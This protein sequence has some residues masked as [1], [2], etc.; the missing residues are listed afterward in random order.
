MNLTEKEKKKKH[1]KTI[2]RQDGQENRGRRIEL[3]TEN[4]SEVTQRLL[5][6]WKKKLMLRRES[7]EKQFINMK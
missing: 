4:V 7:G 6:D 2:E 5:Q 3:K 1:F